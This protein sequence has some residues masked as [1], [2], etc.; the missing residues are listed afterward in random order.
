MIKA[1]VAII[2]MA[3][4]FSLAAL[5]AQ[6]RQTGWVS[7]FEW[8]R[9]ARTLSSKGEMPVSVQ[10]RDRKA[11]GLTL[12]SGEANVRIEK[13]IKGI[14]WHWA[15]GDRVNAVKPKLEK[16]GYKMVSYSEYTRASGLKVRC[17]IWHKR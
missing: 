9:I 11:A 17:A 15:Y 5:P 7:G 8:S 12:N 1:I 4:A 3:G 2:F 10:C 6:A 16:Q 14:K 13:N